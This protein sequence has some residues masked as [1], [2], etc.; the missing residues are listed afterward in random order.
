[1]FA[2]NSGKKVTG[3]I[4]IRAL[5]VASIECAPALTAYFNDSIVTGSFLKLTD[6]TNYR[7]IS[8]LSTL[9]KVF[10]R[11]IRKQIEPFVNSFFSNNLCGFRKSYN[12]QYA[13]LNMIRKWQAC[14]NSKGKVGAVLMDLSK[15]FDCLPHDLLIAKMAA[16]GF[17][18]DSLLLFS[19]YLRDRKHRVRIGSVLSDFLELLLGV[20]QGSVLGPILFNIF[21]NDLLFAVSETSICNFADDNTLYA[22]DTSMDNVL[23]RLNEDLNI[24][25]KWFS[26]NGM[27]ANPAKFQ[28]LF[29]GSDS[30]KFNVNLGHT[31]LKGSNE[32]KLLGVTIDSQ[33]TFHPHIQN[34]C[35]MVSAKINAFYRIRS[36]LTQ[37]QA[38]IL[39]DAYIMSYFNYCP[40]IWMF[41]SKQAH[42]LINKTHHRAL[43][44]KLNIFLCEY[45]DLL[46]LAKLE[47]IHSRNLKLLVI[48]IFKS[49]NCLN[50]KIMWETFP[51]KPNHYNS[52][53]GSC[54]IIPQA[55]STRSVNFFDF[56]SALAWNHLPTSIK[57]QTDLHKFSASLVDI[58]I[59]CKCRECS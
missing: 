1:M 39:F 12:C 10:E 53:Q 28:I 17:G 54:I 57:S 27:L 3:S 22:C 25:A 43:R 55:N 4:P 58:K 40:L 56:R 47:T 5:K 52:R 33:L 11:L 45:D 9:S 49:L 23:Q 51:L 30:T 13:I 59:Y 37:N 6:K 48:E 50:P 44:V 36:Y 21:I 38:D 32:V 26:S 18:R 15:A 46:K 2:L 14:L 24:L 8:L 16:Y 29:P 7:P 35:K 42:N 41:C 19:S 31:I 20:P 34:M